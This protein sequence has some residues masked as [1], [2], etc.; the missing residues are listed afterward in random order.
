MS[1]SPDLRRSRCFCWRVPDTDSKMALIEQGNSAPP[2]NCHR[3]VILG[4]S[5][6]GK[7]SIVSRFLYSKFDDN[8]TPTIEDFHRKIYRIKGNPYRLDILD[9]SGNHPFPAMRRL[10]L[11]TGKPDLIFCFAI[12]SFKYIEIDC[13]FTNRQ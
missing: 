11:I 1:V 13:A 7:T 6:V 10:S 3:L 8:Y 9:T 2:E 5:K 12:S 4:S